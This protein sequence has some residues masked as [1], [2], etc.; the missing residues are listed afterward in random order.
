MEIDEKPRN[1]QI[2]IYSNDN[3]GGVQV[4]RWLVRRFSKSLLKFALFARRKNINSCSVT[5][6][7]TYE[8]TPN[9]ITI[10]IYLYRIA[11]CVVSVYI[12]YIHIVYG[13]ILLCILYQYVSR[14]TPSSSVGSLMYRTYRRLTS[15]YLT[16][17]TWFEGRRVSPSGHVS[18]A[19]QGSFNAFTAA[20]YF[21]RAALRFVWP[22]RS[23]ESEDNSALRSGSEW[24]CIQALLSCKRK[25]A[26]WYDKVREWRENAMSLTFNSDNAHNIVLIVNKSSTEKRQTNPISRAENY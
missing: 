5:C 22:F 2:T 8:H 3:F 6:N 4:W 1:V 26:S 18:K 21:V 19:W 9:V 20:S 7:G 14:W 10:V 16:Q 23:R 25:R 15:F 11:W 12:A 13:V 24:V 17:V